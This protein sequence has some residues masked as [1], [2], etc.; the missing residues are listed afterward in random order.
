MRILVDANIFISYLLTPKKNGTIVATVE[1][2]FD[3]DITVILPSELIDEIIA[4][5]SRKRYLRSYISPDAMTKFLAALIMVSHVPTLLTAFPSFTSDI[6]DDYLVA[7]ALME[8][9]EYLVTGDKQL[10]SLENVEQT[11]IVDPVAY[12]QYLQAYRRRGEA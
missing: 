3:A 11:H 8:N 7:Y 9:V 10:A 4:T 2:C 12:L 1:S 5:R 6:K